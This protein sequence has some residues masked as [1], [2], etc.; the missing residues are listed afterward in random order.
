MAGH[1]PRC[2]RRGRPDLGLLEPGA[3]GGWRRWL[4]L[5]R[6]NWCALNEWRWAGLP[7]QPQDGETE[8]R[9]LLRVKPCPW[10]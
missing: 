3:K 4:A 10:L 7:A 8:A 6:V 2:L 9:R 1:L 5:S